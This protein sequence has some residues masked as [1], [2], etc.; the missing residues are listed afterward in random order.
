MES[1]MESLRIWLEGT[2]ASDLMNNTS[3]A[4]VTAETLHFIGLSLLLGTVGIFDLRLIGLIRNV[5]IS[6]LHRLVRWGILGFGINVATGVLFLSGAPDQYMYNPSFQLKMLF[7]ALA[8][9]N[10]IFF[11]AFAF[12][13]VEALDV[14][15]EADWPARM[16]GLTSLMLWVAVITCGRL[17]TFYRPP[18]YWCPWC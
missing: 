2:A 16:I 14:G 5:P 6:A 9:I 15:S 3:W 18:A 17:L 1:L 7:M 11:Y 8:G 4:W 12:E 13:S 10:V